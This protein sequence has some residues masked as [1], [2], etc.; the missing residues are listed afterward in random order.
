MNE[1]IS[2]ITIDNFAPTLLSAI[3]ELLDRPSRDV[4]TV[5]IRELLGESNNHAEYPRALDQ[6]LSQHPEIAQLHNAFAELTNSQFLDES[7]CAGHSTIPCAV[8]VEEQIPEWVKEGFKQLLSQFVSV[9]PKPGPLH[10]TSQEMPQIIEM[11]DTMEMSDTSETIAQ[12]MRD[13][14]IIMHEGAFPPAVDQFTKG[15]STIHS[16]PEE[17]A[18]AAAVDW[19]PAIELN[20]S[21]FELDDSGMNDIEPSVRQARHEALEYLE[22]LN[23]TTLDSQVKMNIMLLHFAA[24]YSD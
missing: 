1:P 9:L 10:Q 16:A 14:N 4:Y 12:G 6:F 20:E 2:M 11:L 18:M 15:F 19:E 24:M 8:V 5:L 3:K 13:L 7:Q 23:T 17:I 22:K 21:D